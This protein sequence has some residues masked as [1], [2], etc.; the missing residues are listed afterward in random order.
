MNELQHPH[1]LFPSVT[2]FCPHWIAQ[3]SLSNR[4]VPPSCSKR[5]VQPPSKKNP[6]FNHV[7]QPGIYV[8]P[9]L[10]LFHRYARRGVRLC[11][12]FLMGRASKQIVEARATGSLSHAAS[13]PRCK[14]LKVGKNRERERAREREPT[15]AQPCSVEWKR[16]AHRQHCVRAC[17]DSVPAE[18]KTSRNKRVRDWY[19][20][21]RLLSQCVCACVRAA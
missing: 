11:E 15:K 7:G 8:E 5:T 13:K 21:L 20:H 10:R 2:L 3:P 4:S 6:P 9:A 16:W 19:L 17:V 1:H 18:R 14:T 12:G